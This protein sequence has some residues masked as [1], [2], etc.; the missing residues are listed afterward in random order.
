MPAHTL[1][2]APAKSLRTH[3]KHSCHLFALSSRALSLWPQRHVVIFCCR[4]CSGRFFSQSAS[5]WAASVRCWGQEE[6]HSMDPRVGLA[7]LPG[8][9]LW[10]GL[11]TPSL[12][13]AGRDGI[14]SLGRDK[15]GNKNPISTANQVDWLRDEHWRG[16][17]GN[18][19]LTHQK[20][21]WRKRKGLGAFNLAQSFAQ[22]EQPRKA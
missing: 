17:H 22:Y 20:W 9:W 1:W 18:L 8:L 2:L 14:G 10:R 3:S 11:W 12:F 5:R 7:P 16:R 13:N 6:R 15:V 21:K 4:A 19:I